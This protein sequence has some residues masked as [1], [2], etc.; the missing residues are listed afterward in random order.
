MG[1]EELICSLMVQIYSIVITS[2]AGMSQ[3]CREC[4]TTVKMTLRLQC[5][6]RIAVTGSHSEERERQRESR[7]MM[8][9][10]GKTL[11]IFSQHLLTPRLPSLQRRLQISPSYQ[12]AHVLGH[13]FHGMDLQML[14]LQ[15]PLLQHL[16]V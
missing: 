12:E 16:L 11:K 2:L 6:Q 8:N 13:S 1:K 14:Q 3:S 15:L 9:K 7:W 4:W 5:Q 10:S